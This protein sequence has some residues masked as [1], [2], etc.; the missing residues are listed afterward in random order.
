MKNA[1]IISG[2]LL[3]CLFIL[4]FISNA[5]QTNVNLGTN[6]G[7]GGTGNTSIGY[8]AGDVIT[9]V[10]NIFIGYVAG[11]QATSA[12]RNTTL[13]NYTG[14]SQISGTDNVFIGYLTGRQS[15]G[16]SNTF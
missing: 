15:T 2:T 6:A 10:D 7:N 4:P 3:L 14:E 12:T 16:S 5:Q 9:G 8:M 13:G 11:R 1:S